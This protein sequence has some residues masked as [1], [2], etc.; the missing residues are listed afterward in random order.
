M[1]VVYMIKVIVFDFDGVLVDSNNMKKEAF[2]ELFSGNKRV[3]AVANGVL[4]AFWQKTRYEALREIFHKLGEGTSRTAQL[5]ATYN[6]RYNDIVI[7]K[8]KSM[9]LIGDVYQTLDAL[10]GKY[11]LYINS[12][13]PTDA[14]LRT[15]NALGIENFFK[16]IYGVSGFASI[17]D[18]KKL[19]LEKIMKGE[20]VNGNE[21]LFVGDGEADL[22]AAKAYGCEFIGIAHSGNSWAE[23]RDIKTIPSVAE[24]PRILENSRP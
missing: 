23:R 12:A 4:N 2:F 19:N 15:V 5:V 20:E 10:S 11:A 22:A 7:D 14:L 24:L 3:Q 18:T 6:E 8:I 1:N 13:T 21:I 9:G 16:G 17:L